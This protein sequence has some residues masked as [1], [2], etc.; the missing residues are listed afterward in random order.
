M[1][2]FNT[3]DIKEHASVIA[4]CGTEVGKVD[5][6]E[7]QDAIK[8]TRSDDENN[9]HHVIPLSWVSEVKDEQVILN[10]NSEDVRNEWKTL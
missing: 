2:H 8:L 3:T 10:K 9:E 5:H 1:N 6:L 7:G 4:S